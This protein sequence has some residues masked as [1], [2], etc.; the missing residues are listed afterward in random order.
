MGVFGW[1]F[2]PDDA[3]NYSFISGVYLLLTLVSASLFTAQ[4][5]FDVD[6]L[7]GWWI[8]P[9]PC[10]LG[11]LYVLVL[12]SIQNSKTSQARA[13]STKKSQ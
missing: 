2:T 3:L 8:V 6:H 4:Y 11:L 13:T 12:R 10:A 5:V 7:T 1:L 9:A